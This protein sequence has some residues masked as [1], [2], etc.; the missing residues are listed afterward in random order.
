MAVDLQWA[1]QF[2]VA[3]RSQNAV[4]AAEVTFFVAA[5][6]WMDMDTAPRRATP[7]ASRR[8]FAAGR[9]LSAPLVFALCAG[10]AMAASAR[11]LPPALAAGMVG[12]VVGAWLGLWLARPVRGSA[13]L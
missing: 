12:A 11:V 7:D 5:G 3:V 6:P 4:I 8:S 1:A 13:D 10:L 9:L 2:L